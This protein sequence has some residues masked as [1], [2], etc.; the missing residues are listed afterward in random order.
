MSVDVPES[1]KGDVAHALV[2]AGLSVVPIVGGPAVEIF[3][4]LVQPPLERRRT[5]WMEQVGKRLLEL[6]ENGVDISKLQ[7]NDQ[8][9][10]AV[11]YASSA[12]IRTHQQIKLDALKNAIIH[13]ATGDAPEEVLQHL[14]LRFIDEFSE[15][16]FRILAFAQSPVAPDGIS[17]GSLANVLEDNIP[18]LRGQKTLYN[19]LWKDL[20]VRGLV[21]VEGLNSTMS[22]SGLSQ[23]CTSPIGVT[24]LNFIAGP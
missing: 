15:M 1:S 9:I 24:L 21:S 11:M 13:I 6:E 18:S 22:G 10:T 3:Q 14:L 19:Q 2:K 20:Y 16:H 7:E 8:F 17:I 5:A 12:A 23:S 4:L